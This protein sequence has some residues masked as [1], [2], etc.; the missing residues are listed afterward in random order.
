MAYFPDAVGDLFLNKMV[1]LS[2]AA[3]DFICKITRTKSCYT[4]DA[5]HLLIKHQV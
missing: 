1:I 3:S 5:D 4:C 2:G